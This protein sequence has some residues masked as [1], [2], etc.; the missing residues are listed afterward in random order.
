L[1]RFEEHVNY[2][3]TNGGVLPFSQNTNTYY[4]TARLDVAISHNL[5]AFGSWL[6]QYQRQ[7]GED[8]PASDSISP[9]FN[10]ATGCFGAATTDATGAFPCASTGVPKFSY[11]HNLGYAAPNST[12]NAGLDWTITDHMVATTRFGYYFENYHDFGFPTTGNL[13]AWQ[14]NGIGQT[15]AS[16]TA[17]LPASLQQSAGYINAPT[18]INYTSYNANKA[19]QFD[20]DIAWYKSGWGGIHNFKFGYQLNRLSNILNQHFNAPEVNMFVGF[21][22]AG[23]TAYTPAGPTGVANCAP[24]IAAYGQCQGQ[25]GYVE[26]QDFGSNGH[27]TSLN[28]AFFAQDAWTIGHGITIN[29]G[30]RLEHEYLPGE[31]TGSGVPAH[32]IDFGWGS[33][34]APRIGAAWDVFRDGRMKVFGSFGEFYDQM[35]LNLAISSFGGQYWQNCYYALDTA[36]LSTIVPAFNSAGRYCTGDATGEANWAGGATPAGLTFLENQNFRLFP[37]TCT[38]CNLYQE[39]VAPNLHPYEQHESVFGVDYQLTKSLALEARWDRRRLD[40]VIEDSSIFNQALA[41]ETFVIVNP[42]QGVNSTFSGFCNFLYGAGA[43]SACTSSNGQYP[44]N[45]IIPA[46]RSYDG[47]ELR[48]TK[49]QSNHLGGMFSYTYSRFRG[50]YTGLTSS[51]LADGGLGGRNS[52]NNSRSFDEPYFSYNSMGGSSSGLLPTDR[53]NAFKGYGYYELPWLKHF[54]TD[55]GIFQFAYSG[56]PQSSYVDVGLGGS[57]WPVYVFN[58]GTWAD[59]TQDPT[60]GAVTVGQPYTRRTPWFTDTDFNIQQNWKIS[61]SKSLSFTATFTNLLNQHTTTELF[62]QIDTG[63]GYQFLAPPS[64]A[65]APQPGNQC[66]LLNGIDFYTAVTHPYNVSQLL[67]NSLSTGGPITI[68]SQYG[69]PMYYQAARNIRLGVKF[70]F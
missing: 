47:V 60:T 69:K 6:Y 30:I 44:P 18:D 27:A 17:Q 39:G 11:G 49:A 32:P 14:T 8:L 22:P 64:S 2:G 50:N 29:A 35:K 58:R 31:A 63:Y 7:Y 52:P 56:A 24:F 12:T 20:Q 38:T 70:T 66:Y 51:E 23:S 1:N 57:A 19:I 68:N 28:H 33:K 9:Y 42:G 36:D 54:T 61:E 3:P 10:A 59:I 34:V 21:D 13:F 37:T 41:S 67:N 53:P 55:F 45:S 5:R 16:G 40:H 43:S 46:A 15:D 26:V 65:C 48:L 25:Y 4:T 62:S